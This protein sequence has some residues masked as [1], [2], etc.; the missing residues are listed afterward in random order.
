VLALLPFVCFRLPADFATTASPNLG[1]IAFAISSLID[2]SADLLDQR[3]CSFP[4]GAKGGEDGFP[5]PQREQ[6]RDRRE[7]KAGRWSR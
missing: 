3:A 7:M 1:L 6:R 2:G 5:R 4:A